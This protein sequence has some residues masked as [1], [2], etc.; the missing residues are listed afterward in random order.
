MK[1]I[2]RG[3]YIQD[4]QYI[5]KCT[6]LLVRQRAIQTVWPHDLGSNLFRVIGKGRIR[7]KL[8]K[9]KFHEQQRA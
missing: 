6:E 7:V 5:Y 9:E 1:S 8:S 3:C 4:R 2:R